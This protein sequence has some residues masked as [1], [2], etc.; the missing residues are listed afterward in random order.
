MI[1][2]GLNVFFAW[3]GILAGFTLDMDLMTGTHLLML[4][5]V[6]FVVAL[7][8]AARWPRRW[9]AVALVVGMVFPA[10][11]LSSAIVGILRDPKS[12]NLFPIAVAFAT[13][14]TLVPAFVGAG[15]GEMIGRRLRRRRPSSTHLQ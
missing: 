11:T 6:A 8:A 7:I 13:V 5:G 1:S 3:F 15:I 9:W 14:L 2:A 10:Y 12:N 4:G